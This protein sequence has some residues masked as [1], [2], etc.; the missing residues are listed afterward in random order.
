MK[1]PLTW[2]VAGALG[3]IVCGVVQACAVG[4]AV[5]SV[6]GALT[7]VVGRLATVGAALGLIAWFLDGLARRLVKN[8]RNAR[9]VL[10]ALLC[11]A[12]TV[13]IA[14]GTHGH[15]GGAWGAFGFLAIG[16]VG[17]AYAI[18]LVAPLRRPN[19]WPLVALLGCF[20]SVALLVVDPEGLRGTY[21]SLDL[22]L[23]GLGLGAA[24]A[25]LQMALHGKGLLVGLFVA[26]LAVAVPRL[27]DESSADLSTLAT[28]SARVDVVDRVLVASGLWPARRLDEGVTAIEAATLLEPPRSRHEARATFASRRASKPPLNVLWVTIDA[29]RADATGIDG[30]EAA[31]LTPNLDALARSGCAFPDAWSQAPETTGSMESFLTGRY[32]SRTPVASGWRTGEVAFESPSIAERAREAGCDTAWFTG[33]RRDTLAAPIWERLKRGFTT[34]REEQTE[35]P[36]AHRTVAQAIAWLK[37]NRTRFFALVHLF[38]PHAPYVSW[39]GKTDATPRERWESEVRHADAALGELLGALEREGLAEHTI[40]I[41]HADHGEAFNEHGRY[42]HGT[43][44]FQTQIHVPLVIRVPDLDAAV[45]RGPAS[46]IDIAPTLMDLLSATPE[47]GHQGHSLLMRMLEP[48]IP[49]PRMALAETLVVDRDVPWG[50]DRIRAITDGRWKLIE[51]P[52]GPAR[53]L[54]D[55]HADPGEKKNLAAAHSEEVRRLR[56]W[57]AALDA[58]LGSDRASKTSPATTADE[59]M[60]LLTNPEPQA[61]LAAFLALGQEPSRLAAIEDA[62]ASYTP[63]LQHTVMTLIDEFLAADLDGPGRNVPLGAAPS[64]VRFRLLERLG[65]SPRFWNAPMPA[66]PGNLVDAERHALQVALAARG[67]AAA[68][69]HVKSIEPAPPKAWEALLPALARAGDPDTHGLALQLAG[70]GTPPDLLL[71]VLRGLAVSR[72]ESFVAY[73]V[74]RWPHPERQVRVRVLHRIVDIALG[75]DGEMSAAALIALHGNAQPADQERITRRLAE[76]NHSW[77][78]QRVRERSAALTQA[79]FEETAGATPRP[80]DVLIV[81]MEGVAEKP[82]DRVLGTPRLRL[83]NVGTKTI[84]L[85]RGG[86]HHLTLTW[87]SGTGQVPAARVV[88]PRAELEPGAE[89]RVV[90]LLRYPR[91]D[92]RWRL[93]PV[94]SDVTYIGPHGRSWRGPEIARQA[95]ARLPM[96]AL[97][98]S[99]LLEIPDGGDAFSLFG[100]PPDADVLVSI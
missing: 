22:L 37:E 72:P 61:R 96:R 49:W 32:P 68:L 48:G 75:L 88:L 92:G 45:L 50:E 47:P 12:V 39:E 19:R 64:P 27:L 78:P 62:L 74:D 44:F 8:P 54:Y 7:I 2:V 17:V 26:I 90:A 59:L 89:R 36:D 84:V 41:A 14:S 85:G 3:G 23:L 100:V 91:R 98:V 20:V 79:R 60:R 67:N 28:T 43:S 25:G 93:T 6:T 66:T 80:D 16:A 40:V 13:M 35:A 9:A 70:P 5:G 42:Y 24:A 58:R 87:R 86:L 56:G 38:D 51:Y 81:G 77:T 55:L 33:L 52:D 53:L 95:V 76:L 83:R 71:R 65:R 11:G 15:D 30:D 63:G 82:F 34:V 18:A 99:T 4:D 57:I 31:S 46:N 97:K 94:D 69:R 29:L 21:K 1:A 10:L 73:V